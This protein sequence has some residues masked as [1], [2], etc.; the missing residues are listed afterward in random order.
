ME[1]ARKRPAM[2]GST[3][4]HGGVGVPLWEGQ[5][6]YGGSTLSQQILVAP[7]EVRAADVEP[8]AGREDVVDVGP[9]QY[10]GDGA[11][12]MDELKE[13]ASDDL[14]GIVARQFG[15]NGGRQ[16]IYFEGTAECAVGIEVGCRFGGFVEGKL[17]PKAVYRTQKRSIKEFGV[18]CFGRGC[19]ANGSDYLL[20]IDVYPDT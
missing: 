9:G 8:I 1:E 17:M 16:G 14:F 2:E 19:T 7:L 6:L 13:V 12:A 4:P 11:G 10:G 18:R 15:R 3:P 20:V 5:V